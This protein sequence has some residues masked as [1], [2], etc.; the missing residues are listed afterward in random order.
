M[1]RRKGAGGPPLS[2]GRALGQRE[3]PAGAP[4]GSLLA[5]FGNSKQEAERKWV[6][7]DAGLSF[8]F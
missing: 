1:G 7:D 5:C 2:A 4:G 8:F 6:S 3:Q